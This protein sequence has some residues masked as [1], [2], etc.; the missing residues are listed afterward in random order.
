MWKQRTVGWDGGGWI[1][2]RGS[3]SIALFC[4]VQSVS[5]R[6][7]KYHIDAIVAVSMNF[8]RREQDVKGHNRI[9]KLCFSMLAL[10]RATCSIFGELLTTASYQ[11][12]PNPVV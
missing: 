2:R 4:T 3:T 11:H 8:D 12:P 7:S 5:R 9:S 10:H 1:K 6:S